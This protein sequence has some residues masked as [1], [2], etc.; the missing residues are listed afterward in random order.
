MEKVVCGVAGWGA[1]GLGGYGK[2]QAKCRTMVA[3][4]KT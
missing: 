3:R 2:L 1:N 4:W